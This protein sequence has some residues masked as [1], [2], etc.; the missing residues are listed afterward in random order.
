MGTGG[1]SK[2]PVN[3]NEQFGPRDRSPAVKSNKKV[4]C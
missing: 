3:E 1:K 4:T 2:L